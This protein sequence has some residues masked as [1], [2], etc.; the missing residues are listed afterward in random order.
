MTASILR[1]AALP[2][3]FASLAAQDASLRI[4]A[5]TDVEA[6]AAMRDSWSD[7]LAHSRS[8]SVFLSWEWLHSWWTQCAFGRQLAILTVS[9]GGELVAIAPLSRSGPSWTGLPTL[10]FLGTGRVGSDYLDLIIRRGHEEAAVKALANHLAQTRSILDLR[11]ILPASSAAGRMAAAL[12]RLGLLTRANQTS[13]CPF[14][15]LRGLTFEA[16]LASLGSEHRHNFRRRLLKIETKHALKFELVSNEARRLEMLP[17]LFDLHRL[18]WAGRGGDG[19]TGPGILELHEDFSRRAM[20]RGWLR[21]F[22]LWLGDTPAAAVYGFRRGSVFSFYQSGFD[23]RFSKLGV[24]LVAMGLTIKSA[25]EEGALEFDMLHGEEPYKFHWA[26]HSRR[27]SRVLSYP[28][29]VRG[30]A[31]WLGAAAVHTMRG[32]KQRLIPRRV[33]PAFRPRIGGARAATNR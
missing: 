5:V 8:D 29:G 17:V 12:R 9:Q 33:A 6:F 14:I 27:L 25:I 23:P 30:R 4:E 2:R 22:V 19:L 7:L 28:S 20:D 10:Q 18:R 1:V 15:D 11:Q 16:Y 3:P 13:R 32:L 31:T 26:R 24:G 21:L